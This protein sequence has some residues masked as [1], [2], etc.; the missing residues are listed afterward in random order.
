V[1]NEYIKQ[2]QN[3]K[4]QTYGD[5]MKIYEINPFI[6]FATAIRL[7]G[8]T[9]NRSN[10]DCRLF[11]ILNGSARL[12]INDTQYTLSQGSAILFLSGAVYKFYVDNPVTLIS[13]NFDYTQ[14]SRKISGSLSPI[15]AKNFQKNMILENIFFEDAQILN[16]PLQIDK[17]FGLRDKLENITSIYKKL[18]D[19]IHFY[20]SEFHAS[21]L[22]QLADT[23]YCHSH[24]QVQVLPHQCLYHIKNPN[25][26][27]VYPSYL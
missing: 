23:S 15:A 9:E 7:F 11:Y 18:C 26:H 14:N 21:F 3:Y 25:F 4:K 2:T 24:I 10:R 1:Y 19:L 8:N 17:A 20:Y 27:Y 22:R 16:Y 12:V 6:R 5:N 13:I